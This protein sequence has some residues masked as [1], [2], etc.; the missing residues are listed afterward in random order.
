MIVVDDNGPAAS[1]PFSTNAHEGHIQ[2][3]AFD[4]LVH[5]GRNVLRLPIEER[6]ELLTEALRRFN[7]S[8]SLS[9]LM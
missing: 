3:Y 1:T 4:I 7:S 5:R 6:R 8:D 9:R 2:L